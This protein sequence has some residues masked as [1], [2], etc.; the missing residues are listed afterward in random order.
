MSA[1]G[2]KRVNGM[3]GDVKQFRSYDSSRSGEEQTR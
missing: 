2:G 1:V 3:G